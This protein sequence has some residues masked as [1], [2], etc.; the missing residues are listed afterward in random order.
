MKRKPKPETEDLLPEYEFDYAKA[1]RGKYYQRL[2]KEGSNVIVLDPDVAEVFRDS[3]SVNQTLRSVLDL[4]RTTRRIT[5]KPKGR[6][7]AH[8]PG[9]AS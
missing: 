2:M 7:Q 3:A 9:P 6:V 5:A 4:A 8:T 1:V